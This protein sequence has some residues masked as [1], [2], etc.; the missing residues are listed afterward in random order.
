MTPSTIYLCERPTDPRWELGSA[1]ASTQ[2]VLLIGWSRSVQLTEAGV[3]PIVS[4][5]ISHA[6]VSAGHVAFLSNAS[7]AHATAACEFQSLAKDNWP[8]RLGQW[9]HVTPR[10]AGWVI[11]RDALT[12]ATLFDC[13]AF[14]WRLKAQVALL[15]RSPMVLQDLGWDA[16]RDLAGDTWTDAAANLAAVGVE[17][18]LRPGVDGDVAALWTAAP[19]TGVTLRDAMAQAAVQLGAVLEE[20]S[21]AQLLDLMCPRAE[22]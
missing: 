15:V 14:D 9:L 17:A 6:L 16:V 10:S 13:D 18:V 11:T 7:D 5:V 19:A 3:P 20:C 4:R 22:S 12:A 1:A 2:R 21:E 8:M